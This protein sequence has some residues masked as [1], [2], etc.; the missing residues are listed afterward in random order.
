MRLKNL[1]LAG[2][3]IPSY[4]AQAGFG[5]AMQRG[6][7]AAYREGSL[8]AA[9]SLSNDNLIFLAIGGI[10]GVVAVKQGWVKKGFLGT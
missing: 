6:Q 2:L 8:G 9:L 7:G 4:E 10:L 3:G 1:M 5:S